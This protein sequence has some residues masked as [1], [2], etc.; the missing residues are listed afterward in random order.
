MMNRY[1]VINHF[2]SVE[3][4]KHWMCKIENGK[5]DRRKPTFNMCTRKSEEKCLEQFNDRLNSRDTNIKRET[6]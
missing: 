4:K 1:C 3:M 5:W 2:H 6:K